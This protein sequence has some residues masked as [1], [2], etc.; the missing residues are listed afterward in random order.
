M[1][2]FCVVSLL[3]SSLCAWALIRTRW[4]G[5]A[6]VVGI[7]A[8]LGLAFAV[9]VASSAPKTAEAIDPGDALT[10]LAREQYEATKAWRVLGEGPP[11]A[12]AFAVRTPGG[13]FMWVRRATEDRR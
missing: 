1:L 11:P 5:P 2:T 9:F 3:V 10:A 8:A 4:E 12:G 6:R 13:G 7:I